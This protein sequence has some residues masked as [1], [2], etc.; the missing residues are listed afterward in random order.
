MDQIDVVWRWCAIPDGNNKDLKYSMRALTKYANWFRKAFLVVADD[1]PLPMWL[2]ATHERLEII[3]HSQIIPLNYLP[4]Q[5]SN[6]IDSF[7]HNIEDLSEFFIVSDDDTFICQKVQPCYF[8]DPKTFKPINRHHIGKYRHSLRPHKFLYVKMWQKAI[9]EYNIKYTR[10]H[11]QVQPFKK[12]L[13]RVYEATIFKQALLQMVHNRVRTIGD[14]NVLR[15]TT[16]MSS[17]NGDAII[18]FTSDEDEQ[19]Y[20]G[21]YIDDV[22][23]NRIISKKPVFLCINNT[24]PSMRQVYKLLAKLF[25]HKCIFEK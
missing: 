6:V 24:H 17:T 21:E 9:K 18:K 23:V 10:T 16:G 19:F 5:N 7:L 11:H 2:N 15:F 14:I 22:M 1:E 12:S 13:L 8:F 20:E 25:S 4:T 3:R